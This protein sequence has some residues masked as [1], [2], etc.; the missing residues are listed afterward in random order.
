MDLSIKGLRLAEGYLSMHLVGMY[1][2]VVILR[3]FISMFMYFLVAY[4][5][6]AYFRHPTPLPFWLGRRAIPMTTRCWDL[7]LGPR[8]R[9]W[10][11]GPAGRGGLLGYSLASFALKIMEN[12]RHFFGVTLF[13]LAV[14]CS[15]RMGFS[16]WIE[17]M[18]RLNIQAPALHCKVSWGC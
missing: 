4:H 8:L 5:R 16:C 12:P 17:D 11:E 6:H 1:I 14:R 18:A 15:P 13:I 9:C 2:Y 10:D 7:D 3:S